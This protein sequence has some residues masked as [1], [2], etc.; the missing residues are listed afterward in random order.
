MTQK[1]RTN[2]DGAIPI[3]TLL[4]AMSAI[5]QTVYEAG[6]IPSG[7]LYAPLMDRMDL[8]TYQQFIDRL[9]AM[10]LVEETPAHLLRWIG[11][12]DCFLPT[13]HDQRTDTKS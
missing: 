8:H 10:N 12:K 9:K 11:P 2:T 6:E 1:A 13:T 3:E 5:A 4:R 7:H